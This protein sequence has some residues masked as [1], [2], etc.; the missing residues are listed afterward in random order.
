MLFALNLLIPLEKRMSP[1][2]L[3]KG[4]LYQADMFG[5]TSNNEVKK[6][7]NNELVIYMGSENPKGNKLITN[8]RFQVREQ[9]R[10]TDRSFLQY[11]KEINK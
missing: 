11:I 2:D 5:Y 8:Y 1:S 3:V 6:L 4:E 9:Q 7:W 10:L